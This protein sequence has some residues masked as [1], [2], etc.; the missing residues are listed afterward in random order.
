MLRDRPP[1]WPPAAERQIRSAA[2]KV[3]QQ[4][5]FRAYNYV[6]VT[7]TLATS[8]VVAADE[9]AA[10]CEAGYRVVIN[11]LPNDSKYAVPN[12]A[13]LVS[14]LGMQYVHIPVDIERPTFGDYERFEAAMDVASESPVWV[15]C[16]A[17]W[18]VSA[19]VGLYAQ[20]RLGWSRERA[21]E[22]VSGIWE[23]TPPWVQ[24]AKQVLSGS[25]E[26]R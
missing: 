12:E 11:L 5:R 2:V 3:T 14:G 16:A 4:A 22:L 23:P 20:A 18:R 10:I 13:S 19:F 21:A 1:G 9:F 15:H 6:Q 26:N 17:N 25:P 24:L 8:G 7:P